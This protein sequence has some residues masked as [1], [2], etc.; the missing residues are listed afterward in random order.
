VNACLSPDAI[1]LVVSENDQALLR[2]G[3]DRKGWHFPRVE[4]GTAHGPKPADSGEAIDH[5]EGL[6][7]QG[8]QFLLFPK[9]AF[10]WLDE[11][12]FYRGFKKHVEKRYPVVVRQ[13]D[14]CIIF[15][16]R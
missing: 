8:A 15:D 3:A 2:L 12:G 6:R 11:D 13:P 16:L 5:L 1:V 9:S 10:W 14:A 7:R 4:G